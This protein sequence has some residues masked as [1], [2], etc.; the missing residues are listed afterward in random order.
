MSEKSTISIACPKCLSPI[1]VAVTKGHHNLAHHPIVLYEKDCANESSIGIHTSCKVCGLPLTHEQCGHLLEASTEVSYWGWQYGKAFLD[2]L[3]SK[4]NI[5]ERYLL[6]ST[7]V[8]TYLSSVITAAIIG[9]VAYDT[10][11]SFCIGI[12]KKLKESKASP[13]VINEQSE[14]MDFESLYSLADTYL[15]FKET[16]FGEPRDLEKVFHVLKYKEPSRFLRNNQLQELADIFGKY[17][18]THNFQM[19]TSSS[20]HVDYLLLVW[21]IFN[22]IGRDEVL[23]HLINKQLKQATQRLMYHIKPGS[24]SK[25]REERLSFLQK[26]GAERLTNVPRDSRNLAL[27]LEV[28]ENAVL[29]IE[30]IDDAVLSLEIK[31]NCVT[32]IDNGVGMSYRDIFYYYLYPHKSGWFQLGHLKKERHYE[33]GGFGVKK[34]LLSCE[35]LRIESKSVNDEYAHVAL[36]IGSK[37]NSRLWFPEETRDLFPYR[38]TKVSLELSIGPQLPDF[39]RW[40]L[41]QSSYQDIEDY[42]IETVS[43]YCRMVDDR[44]K[45]FLNGKRLNTLRNRGDGSYQIIVDEFPELLD[46]IRNVP[47][48]IYWADCDKDIQRA[49]N[50]EDTTQEIVNDFPDDASPL[51]VDMFRSFSDRD[52]EKRQDFCLYE[53]YHNGLHVST[54]DLFH[55]LREEGIVLKSSALRKLNHKTIRFFLPPVVKLVWEKGAI[56]S[57]KRNEAYLAKKMLELIK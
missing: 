15:H 24:N 13:Q 40:G 37:H 30:D 21:L 38:G 18:P 26:R 3:R 28:I 22:H 7:E 47:V 55:L 27:V 6:E 32:V 16:P 43:R 1:D 48:D 14:E 2:E 19:E 51:L 36:T 25:E 33:H 39:L 49:N 5:R 44:I 46:N 9:G 41:W 56:V 42:I 8:L 29:A 12:I 4:G 17:N 35:E 57:Y 10:V 20:D 34:N 52:E 11:K 53:I 31:G 23:E 45:V 50:A 54:G